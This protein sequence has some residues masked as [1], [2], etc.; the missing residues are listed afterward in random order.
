MYVNQKIMLGHDRMMKEV[1]VR[2]IKEDGRIG[3]RF[4]G[5]FF[6][7]NVV[8]KALI[9]GQKVDALIKGIKNTSAIIKISTSNIALNWDKVGDRNY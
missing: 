4:Y 1:T 3:I 7:K 2:V 5:K 9:D 6:E 8:V